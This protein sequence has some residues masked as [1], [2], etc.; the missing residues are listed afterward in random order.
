MIDLFQSTT[1]LIVEN[2]NFAED[3]K[4]DFDIENCCI[5][6]WL[7]IAFDA[8]IAADYRLMHIH[9][10]LVHCHCSFFAKNF[11][12]QNDCYYT[13]LVA[14]E[15]YSQIDRYCIHRHCYHVVHFSIYFIIF[16]FFIYQSEKKI[17]NDVRF[18]RITQIT[19]KFE[20]YVVVNKTNLKKNIHFREFCC[21]SNN[22]SI[23]QWFTFS[24]SV[25]HD[26]TFFDDN[27]HDNKKRFFEAFAKNKHSL[28]DIF[29]E[30]DE[31]FLFFDQYNNISSHCCFTKTNIQILT[32]KLDIFDVNHIFDTIYEIIDVT[33]INVFVNMLH[34]FF[35]DSRLVIVIEVKKV[36]FVDIST[37]E[38][39]IVVV[40]VLRRRRVLRI[41]WFKW[42]KWIKLLIHKISN[43]SSLSKA[44]V[45]VLIIVIL[46][47]RH[48]FVHRNE[49]N[50]IDNKLTNDRLMITA[51]LNKMFLIFSWLNVE[52]E[53]RSETTIIDFECWKKWK[54]CWKRRIV[55]KN[56]CYWKKCRLS[57]NSDEKLKT[58]TFCFWNWKFHKWAKVWVK[59]SRSEIL[60]NSFVVDNIFVKSFNVSTK[61]CFVQKSIEKIWR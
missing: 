18:R 4:H 12:H 58:K 15:S 26:I 25:F 17:H 23:F 36:N 24:T 13:N 50:K 32:N 31:T 39:V 9:N 3:N 35:D 48:V 22:M 49:I 55:F 27:D 54:R 34:D 44:E 19:T 20:V 43:D 42:I 14:I 60:K 33:K 41:W 51:W 45:D 52:N 1:I 7:N 21:F 40:D 59:K 16:F 2:D 28:V 56:K 57:K 29:I 11:H 6:K 37:I 10:R 61:C 47:R 46:L 8:M 5:D 38:V 30:F 53:N